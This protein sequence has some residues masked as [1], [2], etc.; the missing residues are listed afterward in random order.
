M[1]K[2][3]TA[4]FALASLV[5][6][7]EILRVNITDDALQHRLC[8]ATTVGYQVL[9]QTLASIQR[10]HVNFYNDP[11]NKWYQLKTNGTKRYKMVKNNEHKEKMLMLYVPPTEKGDADV[12]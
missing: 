2:R 5:S 6:A 11:L 1:F 4:I 8:V 9:T 3:L 10:R 12:R 7:A